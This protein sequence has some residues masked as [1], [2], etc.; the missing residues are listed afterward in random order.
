LQRDGGGEIVKREREGSSRMGLGAMGEK[1]EVHQS[2]Q[3][4]RTHNAN[5][6]RVQRGN[7][8]TIKGKRKGQTFKVGS[9][10]VFWGGEE[11]GDACISAARKR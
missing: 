10:E 11:K 6:G 8:K 3:N 9:K 2:R 7:S 1:K 4:L 5:V